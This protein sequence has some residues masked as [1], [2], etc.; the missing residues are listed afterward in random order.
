[1]E[2]AKEQLQSE[3]YK[4]R[5]VRTNQA[6]EL[7]LP[8]AAAIKQLAAAFELVKQVASARAKRGS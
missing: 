5:T 3:V 6:A 8:F 1:M 7:K 4:Q 2:K